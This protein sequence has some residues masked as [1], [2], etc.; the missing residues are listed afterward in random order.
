M[1]DRIAD[2]RAG[3]GGELAEKG[4]DD[5]LR[6]DLHLALGKPLRTGREGQEPGEMSGEFTG[7]AAD[8]ALAEDASN[9]GAD[10]LRQP[11]QNIAHCPL[12]GD[13][14]IQDASPEKMMSPRFGDLLR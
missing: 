11:G 14:I 6:I 4:A 8:L 2:G 12:R 7:L 5:A 10:R 9:G 3:H 1:A 13:L